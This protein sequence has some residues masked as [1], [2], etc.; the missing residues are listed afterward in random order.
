[1]V[2][3]YLSKHIF[4]LNIFI[5]PDRDNPVEQELWTQYVQLATAFVVEALKLNDKVIL[6][7][8]TYLIIT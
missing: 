3:I 4:L 2:H 8:I 7:V 5:Y 1:M 6:E